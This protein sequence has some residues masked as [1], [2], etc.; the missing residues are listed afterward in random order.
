MTYDII[1]LDIKTDPW[2]TTDMGIFF[3][4]DQGI[5]RIDELE[6]I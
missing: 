6:D 2:H 4:F 1:L 5:L 3:I